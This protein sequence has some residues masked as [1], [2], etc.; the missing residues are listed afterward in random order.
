MKKIIMVC[1]FAAV[2]ATGFSQIK[3]GVKTGVNFSNLKSE[4]ESMDSRLA[5]LVGGFAEFSFNDKLAFRPE[6]VYSMEGAKDE[7]SEDGFDIEETIKLDY[8]NLPL[9]VKYKI[10]NGISVIAGPQV[11]FLLSAKAKMESGSSSATEDIKEYLK[12]TNLSFSLGAGWEAENGLGV[13]LRY[14]LG[15]SNIAD[16]EDADLKTKSL[17]LSVFYTF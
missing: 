5:P 13:D 3:F 1:L 16:D 4:D 2:A 17:Q 9:L 10:A 14:N 8:L 7:Y 6:L 15:L 11:G 12:G